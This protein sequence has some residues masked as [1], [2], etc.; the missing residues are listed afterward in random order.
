MGIR[1]ASLT[2]RLAAL[3][4]GLAALVLVP[5]VASVGRTEAAWVNAEHATM[6]ATA[7]RVVIME[8]PMCPLTNSVLLVG[9]TRANPT[10][11]MPTG[12]TGAQVQPSSLASGLETSGGVTV[13]GYSAATTVT[14]GAPTSLAVDVGSLALGTS[15]IVIVP[16][17][18]TWPGT[19][20]TAT[21]TGDAISYS[22]VISQG[23]LGRYI[24]RCT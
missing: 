21:W 11:T 10:F 22:T 1:T 23:V 5:T 18:S 12:A 6:T 2:R 9:T 24:S 3:S 16:S 19:S 4:V 20:S 15:T 17:R 8:S 14:S 13:T 7:T